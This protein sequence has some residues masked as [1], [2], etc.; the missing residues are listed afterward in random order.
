[1]P[2]NTLLIFVKNSV[3]G[4]TKTRLA[5]S[6]GDQKALKVY[7]KLVEHT[8]AVTHPLQANKEVWYSSNI[9]QDDIWQNEGFT[10]KIQK[11]DDL[12]ERMK[13]AFKEAFE[14]TAKKAVIIGSDN[15]EITSEIIEKAF[16]ALDEI[17]IVIGPAK[18]GG[19]YLLGMKKYQPQ[20]FDGIEWSTDKVLDST[21]QIIKEYGNTFALLK[22]LNDVDTIDDWIEIKNDLLR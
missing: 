5:K 12:G 14:G 6:I 22:A 17:D 10:K 20:V 13:H 21:I 8:H 11:G 2:Q 18:D 16:K 3:P 15:A 19:Y 7:H 1:M 9:Q 4:K